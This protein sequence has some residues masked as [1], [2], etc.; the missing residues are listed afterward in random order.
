MG[1]GSSGRWGSSVRARLLALAVPLALAATVGCLGSKQSIPPE[2]VADKV[3][4][5][6]GQTEDYHSDGTDAVS[7]LALAMQGDAPDRPADKPINV[8]CV[9]GGGKYAAFTAGVL[10]GWTATGDR[11]KFDVATGVSSGAPT[12]LMAFLGPK[13]DHQLADLF[14]NLNRS[15]LYVWRPIRG[16]ITGSGLMSSRPLYK[17]LDRKLNE[18]V[19]ADLRA[20]HA[21]GRRLFIAT[22][23]VRTHKMVVWD[24]G[25]IASSG[26][27]D[28]GEMVRKVFLA[29][30]SIPGLVPPVEFDVTVNGVRYTELHADAGNLAQV[31]V[32]TCGPLPPGSSV[33][34]LS[35]GKAHPNGAKGTPR[36]LESMVMAVSTTLYALF[37]A[38]AL[39]LY[40][41]CGVTRS[42]FRMLVIPK[43]FEGRTNSMA[44]DHEE[45]RRMYVIG[46]QLAVGDMWE[47]RPPDTAPGE[48]PP[49]R[50]GVE[51]VTAE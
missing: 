43:A 29:A 3:W 22:S 45:S 25:A 12:A 15:D 50:T 16:L 14:L 47:T 27:P 4:R 24:V 10:C 19:L 13:Y 39:R 21:E 20:A 5:N 31:F 18:S 35:A 30:C 46:Y 7:G 38:D 1:T 37:R 34:V 6:V 26:R 17:L 2:S 11:P 41:L 49:P 36:V 48:E 33:W 40:A 51:F 28:A 23:N 32:R 9:S 42:R 8:V 44:F